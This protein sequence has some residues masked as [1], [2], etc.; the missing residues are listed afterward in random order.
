M[1]SAYTKLTRRHRTIG[2]YTQLWLA[3]DHIL[4]LNNSRIAEEYKR[5]ALSD[6]QSIV[7]TR[8]PPQIVLQIVMIVAALAWMALWF[9][10]DS[11][12]GKWA[13]IVTGVLALLTPLS[14][15]PAARAA[16]VI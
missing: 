8:L 9:T 16:G 2:G 10:V 1:P 5:F 3:S 4:L 15:S 14:I 12:F 11:Q 7:V 13:F 6:I